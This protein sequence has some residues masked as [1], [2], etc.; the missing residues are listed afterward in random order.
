[1]DKKYNFRYDPLYRV[2]DEIGELRIVEGNFKS[3]FDRMKRIN[4]LGII[5]EVFEM[6]RYPKYEH[7]L[8]TMYQIISL[9]D[10]ADKNII[11]TK[12]RKPLILA[13]L[14]L[15][16][17]HFPYTYSTERALLLASNLGH[18][19]KEN[20]IKKYAKSKIEKVLNKI[21][22]ND[23]GKQY[24]L[25]NIFS[26]CDYELL[27]RYFSAEI[28]V[29]KFS[30]LK[31]KVDGLSE[32]DLEVIIRDLVDKENDGY[33]YLSLANKADFVQ[34]DALYFGT[35]RIDVSPKH[36]Y[37][38]ISRYNPSYSVSEEKLI[39]YNLNY[40]TERFYDNPSIVWFSRLY[41]KI[42]ASLIISKN[43]KFEWIEK[44]D[45]SQF[46]RLICDGLDKD[47]NKRGLPSK[48]LRRTKELFEKK[49]SFS[50]IF[51]LNEVSFQK[52]KDVVDIEYELIGK[53]ESERGLLT[54]PFV[55]GILLAI[56]YLN[57][58][59]Y[60]VHQNYRA[61]S[62]RVFQNESNR[63]LEK[64]LNVIRNLS[65]YLSSSHID[66]I[67]RG[68][69]NQ[70]SWTKEV[71][72]SNEAVIRAISD[73]IQS[74]ENN[75]YKKGDF[76][77]K[78]LKSISN[79][80]SFDELWHNFENLLVWMGQI[81]HFLQQ[82]RKELEEWGIYEKF[83]KGLLSLPV[84]LLQYKSTKRYLDEIYDKL[85]EKISSDISDDKK[86]DFF[87]TLLLIDK[88]R[89]KRGKFQ[90]FLNG[91]V[92]IDSDKPRDKQDDNEFDVIELFVNKNGKAECW[93]YACSIADDYE[94]KN[95]EQITKLADHIHEV[96]PHLI[97]QTRYVIPN[98]KNAGDWAPM[99]KNA[100]RGYS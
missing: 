24:I 74:I 83:T 28:L 95:R 80:S 25:D 86:G 41:E 61:F 71:R 72:F 52:K 78:Y 16:L 43:F 59:D 42:V 84:Q 35:V 17:G 85:L 51:N 5:P 47:N 82:H 91:M 75:K 27:Y 56:D 53:R 89:T 37:G 40:L 92:V 54:Y 39:E 48:W 8:G 77:E 13:S 64:L 67:R 14:F 93:I 9:L 21:S 7:G 68:L 49:I 60:P 63:S 44:Y 3:L 15:H 1:M 26:L 90:F 79:I 19:G 10:V 96:F 33:T 81:V 70:L 98:D 12:Y 57:K 73:A 2:I 66:T 69:A 87:E 99:E 20:K 97:V 65:H 46:K 4:N 38:G 94:P 62:I 58:V 34:R 76:I 30:N 23:K 88:I 36:L 32:E 100:G 29:E 22:L 18:R 55:T 50:L 6:A 31:D 11:P 45:D